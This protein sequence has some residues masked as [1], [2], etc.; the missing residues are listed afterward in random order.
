MPP[1]PGFVEL[2]PKPFFDHRHFLPI[3]QTR[4][5]RQ[6]EAKELA[7]DPQLRLVGARSSDSWGDTWKEGTARGI[8]VQPWQEERGAV[9][10]GYEELISAPLQGEI[11]D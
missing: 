7:H 10:R 8:C 11:L 2:L 9:G 3:L 4:K 5:L 1:Q 6:R